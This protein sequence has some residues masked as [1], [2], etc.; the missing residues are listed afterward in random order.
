MQLVFD[1]PLICAEHGRAIIHLVYLPDDISDI[2]NDLPLA[3]HG[4]QS[5]KVVAGVGAT[6]WPT[7]LFPSGANFL[8]LIARK[9]IMREGLAVGFP[10]EV[11]LDI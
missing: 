4:F 7:S 1:A 11:T 8:L 6:T 5:I 9:V 2:L 3:R 10:V